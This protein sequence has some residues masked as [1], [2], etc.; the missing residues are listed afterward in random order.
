MT[1]KK[2]RSKLVVVSCILFSDRIFQKHQI[3]EHVD[4]EEVPSLL[5]KQLKISGLGRS[6]NTSTV[7]D[8]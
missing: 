2:S 7:S 1:N 5:E 3:M 8:T 6:S 4:D